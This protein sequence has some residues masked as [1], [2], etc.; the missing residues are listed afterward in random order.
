MPL[1]YAFTLLF[2]RDITIV[3]SS[4]SL[5]KHWD[6]A[7]RSFPVI[8]LTSANPSTFN[9]DNQYRQ[10]EFLNAVSY[11]IQIQSLGEQFQLV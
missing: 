10:K 5:Y 9:F 2:E 6:L 7:M 8:L 3:S 4:P 11:R 1:L